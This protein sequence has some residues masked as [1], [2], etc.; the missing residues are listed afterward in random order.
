MKVIPFEPDHLKTLALQDSQTWLMP[1][2]NPEYGESLLKAGDCFTAIEGDEILG[3]AGTMKIWEGRIIAWALISGKSGA[4]FVGIFKAI[5]RYLDL[6]D[7]RRIEAT[8]DVDFKEGHRLMRL[9]GF[10]YE[11]LMR[12]YLADGRDMCLYARVR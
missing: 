8:V 3:C 1:M 4:H 11:G 12:K 6:N 2:L 10:E 5:K 9:L 7:A